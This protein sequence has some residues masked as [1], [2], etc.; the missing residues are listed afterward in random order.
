M[1]SI[2]MISKM[3][4]CIANSKQ[5]ETM[6]IDDIDREIRK[7]TMGSSIYDHFEMR[8][9]ELGQFLRKRSKMF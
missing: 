2:D 6:Y 9:D 8:G 7:H 4:W 1:S 3:I 5:N